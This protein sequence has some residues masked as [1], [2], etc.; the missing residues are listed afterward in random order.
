MSIKDFGRKIK[1]LIGKL[2][3][4]IRNLKA[5]P[6]IQDDISIVVLIILVG[7][8]SFGLGRLSSLEKE[9]PPIVVEKTATAALAGDTT[10]MITRVGGAPNQKGL[11]FASKSGTKYYYPWCSGA[12]RVKEENRKWFP[13]V[14][15]AKAAGL[16]PAANCPGLE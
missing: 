10:P 12:A 15:L 6:D 4:R 7:L 5:T 2:T 13:S 8:S 14:A 16:T 11:V 3:A 9:Q 1:P